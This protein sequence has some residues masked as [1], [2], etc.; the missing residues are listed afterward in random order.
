LMQNDVA[1]Y[2]SPL[3]LSA[4]VYL[5]KTEQAALVLPI[6]LLI[7]SV[8]IV[9]NRRGAAQELWRNRAIR[10]VWLVTG[11]SLLM[12]SKLSAPVWNA[13][14]QFVYRSFPFRWLVIPTAGTCIIG[15][16][17][18]SALGGNIKLRLVCSAALAAAIVFGLVIS[19]FIIA[20]APYEAGAF[21]A[22]DPR[23][24]V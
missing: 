21:D 24:E 4:Y 18:L 11:I 7:S 3:N 1:S 5:L 13:I 12:S 6:L 22:S 16:A 15:G 14:P 10:S 23:R 19:G 8:V 2:S 17:A 9:L 20:R